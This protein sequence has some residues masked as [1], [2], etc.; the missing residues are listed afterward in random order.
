MYVHIIIFLTQY[1]HL[2]NPA[3]QWIAIVGFEAS[4]FNA[5]LFAKEE[6]DDGAPGNDEKW[7]CGTFLLVNVY[8]VIFSQ[9]EIMVFDGGY[10]SGNS[11][12]Y[13]KG[14]KVGINKI[15]S[16]KTLILL[17]FSNESLYVR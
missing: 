16:T 10:P 11:S 15:S 13:Y 12:S 2:P 9:F 4:Y 1:T 5:L 14:V 6:D 17:S 7:V 3:T 8:L